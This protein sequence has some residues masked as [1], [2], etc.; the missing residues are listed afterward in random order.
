MSEIR[1]VEPS[2][3]HAMVAAGALLLDVRE[4]VEWEAGHPPDAHHVPMADVPD[5]LDQLPRDETVVVFCRS[6]V[7]SLKTAEFLVAQG[8]DAVNLAGGAKAWT[9]DDFPFVDGAGRDGVVA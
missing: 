2:E 5:H 3:G 8:F 4:P 7:R 9:A 6:G 1:E